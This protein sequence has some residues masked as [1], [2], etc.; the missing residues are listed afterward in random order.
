MV[1]LTNSH[2][3]PVQPSPTA[4]SNGNHAV[5]YE[6][7]MLGILLRARTNMTLEETAI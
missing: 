1:L 7:R 2:Y 4:L 3:F 6:V 5:L